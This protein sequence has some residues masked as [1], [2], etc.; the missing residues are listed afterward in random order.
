MYATSTQGTL[1]GILI[2]LYHLDNSELT[3]KALNCKTGYTVHT[4]MDRILFSIL[5]A[6]IQL[7]SRFLGWDS[8]LECVAREWSTDIMSRQLPLILK[9]VGPTHYITQ[10][11][12][13][14][15]NVVL[16]VNFPE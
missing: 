12:E 1:P 11:G 2:S 9:G 7:F 13:N 5:Y 14:Q 4:I 15:Y 3:L 10:F 16:C 8:L 6:C